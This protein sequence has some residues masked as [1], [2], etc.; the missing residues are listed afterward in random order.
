M[1]DADLLTSL[2]WAGVK[3]VQGDA[4][5]AAALPDI[6]TPVTQ[7]IAVGKAAAT[8]ARPAAQAYPHAPCL[9]VTKYDHADDA[10]SAAEL[11]DAEQACGADALLLML[12]SGGASALAEAL[13]EGWDLTALAGETERLLASGADIHAMNARLKDISQIK[14]GKLLYDFGVAIFTRLSI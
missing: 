1:T 5:V 6:T 3:A 9:I 7:I 10:P 2:W 12:V 13:P 11:R 14:F 4:A 8:M